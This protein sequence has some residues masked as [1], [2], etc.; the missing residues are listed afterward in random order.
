MD[1]NIRAARFLA[2]TMMMKSAVRSRSEKIHEKDITTDSSSKSK[3][4]SSSSSSALDRYTKSKQ[5]TLYEKVEKSTA[6]LGDCIDKMLE[7]GKKSDSEEN[8]KNTMMSYINTFVADYNTTYS[9]L[10]SLSG[11]LDKLYKEQLGEL[12][13]SYAGELKKLGITVSDSGELIIDAEK[14]KSAEYDDIKAVFG[15]SG[16]YA[17]TLSQKLDIINKFASSSLSSMDNLYGTGTYDK[18]G[19]STDYTNWWD[20]L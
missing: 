9:S 7:M 1:T 13:D 10:N 3:K 18:Y 4:S 15:T 6:S 16:G 19:N 12:T 5:T 20:Q 14:L 11:T 2:K 8:D 17:D